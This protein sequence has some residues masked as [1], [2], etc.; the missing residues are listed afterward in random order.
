MVA[1]A[2][3]EGV[4]NVV[5]APV[6]F[7]PRVSQQGCSMDVDALLEHTV[8]LRAGEV[9][10]GHGFAHL[11]GRRETS[12]VSD[13]FL[14]DDVVRVVEVKHPLPLVEVFTEKVH[15]YRPP[16]PS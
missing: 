13:V 8:V 12:C 15:I 3:V 9:H 1:Y 16:I 4:V 14:A 11:L 5:A 7:V 10:A 6:L 2:L